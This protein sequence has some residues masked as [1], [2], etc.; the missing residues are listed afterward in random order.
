MGRK[1]PFPSAPPAA[2]VRSIRR[3]PR[4]AAMTNRKP[5]YLQ[6]LPAKIARLEHSGSILS[7][8]ALLRILKAAGYRVHIIQPTWH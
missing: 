6:E 7:P 2:N 3:S 8:A 1:F 5:H 4:A